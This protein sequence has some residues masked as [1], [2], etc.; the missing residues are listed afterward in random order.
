MKVWSI[1]W[2]DNLMRFRDRNGLLLMLAAPL[3]LAAIVGAAFGGFG[4][5][6]SNAPLTA[7]PIAVVN[8]DAGALGGQV[9][10]MLKSESLA[11]LLAPVEMNDPEAAR[12]SVEAGD[13]RGV[14]VIPA[15][16]SAAVRAAANP[17]AGAARSTL[18]LEVDPTAAISPLILRAIVSQIADGFN[19]GAVG[20]RVAIDQLAQRGRLAA[21]AARAPEVIGRLSAQDAERGQAGICQEECVNG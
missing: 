3:V 19:S 20:G 9:V 15:D 14:V 16:F 21:V 17:A 11:G 5:G 18:T 8:E 12:Q 2:K 10:Q 13:L 4:G 6:G 7:M 1:A